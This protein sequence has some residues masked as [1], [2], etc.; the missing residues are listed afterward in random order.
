MLGGVPYSFTC[1][2]PKGAVRFF[3]LETKMKAAMKLASL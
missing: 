1:C 2:F 3:L